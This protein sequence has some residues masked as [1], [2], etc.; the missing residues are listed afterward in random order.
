MEEKTNSKRLFLFNPDC[1]LAIANGNRFYMPP[2]N[3]IK[4]AEDLAFLPAW[5]GKEGDCVLVKELPDLHFMRTVN[6]LLSLRCLPVLESKLDKYDDITGVPW[7]KS[8][9]MC[10]WLAERGWGEEWK[11]EQKEWYSRKT[12]REG[13]EQLIEALPFVEKEVLP[14]I[15]FTLTE[16]EA[17]ASRGNW[18]VKAPWSSSGKGL[19][20]LENGI[21]PKEKEWLNGMFR[22]QGYLMLEKKLD[23]TEDFAMEFLVGEKG[24]RFIG[25]SS[26]STGI[27][28]EYTG[29]FLGSQ[30]SI[31]DRLVCQLGEQVIEALKR[32]VP[33]MLMKILPRYHG[34]LG[35]DMMVYRQDQGKLAVQPCVE[36]NLR[37]N[38]GILALFLSHFHLSEGTQGKFVIHFYPEAGRACQ[39][40]FRLQQAFPVIY[41]NNRIKSGYLNLTPVTE[42]THFVASVHCY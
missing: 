31:E 30:K 26:F 8:P 37:Y 3:I 40:H 18:L 20:M 23:K 16:L 19:L 34:Y 33:R 11:P 6:E 9:K 35:I 38:M 21:S 24:V 17:K 7:G 28:G 13:L 12:A 42:T 29:N 15:C 39:E 36:I 5:L 14:R 25:W 22:R 2:A 10:H 1:E 4:M 32:E 27:R 41:K